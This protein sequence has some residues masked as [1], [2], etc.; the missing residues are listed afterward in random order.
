MRFVRKILIS[1]VFSIILI[2]FSFNFSFVPCKLK[3]NILG[4]GEKWDF[5]SFSLTGK[6]IGE[7][8]Y[9]G[10][11][12]DILLSLTVL[13]LFSFLFFFIVISFIFRNKKN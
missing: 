10:K 1:L 7:I 9:F 8:S 12:D 4:V 6:T 5:C 11:Y 13:F 2:S 3:S